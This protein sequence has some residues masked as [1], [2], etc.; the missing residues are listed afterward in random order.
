MGISKLMVRASL[1]GLAFGL[2]QGCTTVRD[3]IADDSVR[4]VESLYKS[5]VY[6]T[7]SRIPRL[8]DAR[9]PIETQSPQPVKVV[10]VSR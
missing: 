10:R 6:I 5:R 4:V 2:V 1:V 8:I 9:K 3:P 7:G